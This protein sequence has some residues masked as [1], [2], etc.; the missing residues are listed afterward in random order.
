MKSKIK[1]NKTKDFYGENSN[2]D[3]SL[4]IINPSY[5]TM[6][7]TI[8]SS[9]NSS[10]SGPMQNST[11]MDLIYH[12]ILIVFPNGYKISKK[13][14]SR[15]LMLFKSQILANNNLYAKYFF[16]K[17][18]YDLLIELSA[19]AKLIPT[20]YKLKLYNQEE[21]ATEE[22]PLKIIEYT[23]NQTIGQLSK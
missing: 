2:I 13:I 4:K 15:Y 3:Q 11:E 21:T 14:D 16:R 22:D 1:L 19:A 18:I 9:T 10:L 6:S 23:P 7:S 8:T 12:E 17:A 5:S 20:N